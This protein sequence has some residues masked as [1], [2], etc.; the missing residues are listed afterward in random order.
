MVFFCVSFLEVQEK[1]KERRRIFYFFIFIEGR[2]RGELDDDGRC[3]EGKKTV[4]LK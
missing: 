3:I 1:L 2:R 4:S